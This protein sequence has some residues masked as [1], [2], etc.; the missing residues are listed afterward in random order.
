MP[1]HFQHR[2]ARLSFLGLLLGASM[3]AL[4]APLQSGEAIYQKVCI[5]CHGSGPVDAPK[6]GDKAAW[7]PLLTEGQAVVTAHG[8]VGVRE[9]PP[10]GGAPKLKLEEF[11]RAVAYMGRAAGGE[12]QDPDKSPALMA[13]IRTEE[14]SRREEMQAQMQAAADQGRSG[15]A[16]YG[17]VCHHCHED[18][19]AGAP[20]KGDRKA[21]G[22]LVREGQAVLTA[23]AWVGIRAMPPRGGHPDLSLEEFSRAVADM[24]SASGGN[25]QDPSSNAQLMKQIRAEIAKRERRLAK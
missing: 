25:W 17:E 24:A 18:G 8:W 1:I 2:T 4:A 6:L 15:A 10:K 7:E 16:V 9:M 22:S 11:G 12:W 23:H 14:K 5:A 19:V 13:A 3:S 20:R 21:W